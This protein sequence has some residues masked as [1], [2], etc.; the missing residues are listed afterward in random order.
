[1]NHIDFVKVRRENIRWHLLTIANVS[2]PEG[3]YTEAMLPVIQAVYIDAT[4][5]EVR[6]ELEYLEERGLVKI[7]A[8]PLGRWFVELQRHG[9]DLVEYTV[10]IEP[11]IARPRIG[12]AA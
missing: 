4:E 8:D 10:E 6:R 12:G 9:I 7:K 2:R 5:K 11:G 3:V 1:M